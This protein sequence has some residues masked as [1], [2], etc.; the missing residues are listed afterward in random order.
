MHIVCKH[1]TA[2]FSCIYSAFVY[3]CPLLLAC[4]GWSE[5]G[6]LFQ[7]ESGFS[8]EELAEEGYTNPHLN[9]AFSTPCTEVLDDVCEDVI[10]ELLMAALASDCE[11][12]DGSIAPSAST[13]TAELSDAMCDEVLEDFIYVL[14]SECDSSDEESSSSPSPCIAVESPALATM[15]GSVHDVPSGESQKAADVPSDE[16]VALSSDCPHSRGSVAMLEDVDCKATHI[17]AT[18]IAGPTQEAA[19]DLKVEEEV[20]YPFECVSADLCYSVLAFSFC[21]Q[22]CF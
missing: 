10:E 12:F 20:S 19:C 17:S 1:V 13:A 15:P 5:C 7:R 11:S 22:S 3:W 6:D 16:T 18:A 4:R 21:K 8:C 14:S 9:T 2:T